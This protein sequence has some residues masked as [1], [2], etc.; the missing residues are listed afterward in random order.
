MDWMLF[1][2]FFA[3]CCAAASTGAMFMPDQWYRD[4]DK[5]G[6]TPPD[7]V[8]PVT[9]T[10]LY[11]AIAVA[12]ARVAPLSENAYAM[13]FWALQMVLNAL[14]SPVF[15]GLHKIKAGAIVVVCLWLAVLGAMVALWSLDTI[16]GILFVPYLIWVTI[17]A[18]L[19]LTI[20]KLNP[21]E[22]AEAA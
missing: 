16:A 3:A 17:A 12:A 13:G 4:I 10:I 15:F 14:W 20:W 18:S 1:I 6:W 11:V 21:E 2:I 9:W 8:F 5:P 22:A 7:W 19:N